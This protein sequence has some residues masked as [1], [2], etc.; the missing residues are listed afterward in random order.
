MLARIELS[1]VTTILD[2]G[3][4]EGRF[5][6][7][8]AARGLQTAGIDPSQSLIRQARLLHPQGDYRAAYAEELPFDDRT[9]DAV[10]AYM[11]LIDIPD[12]KA[13]IREMDRV[14]RPGGQ[15]LIA[16]LNGFCSASNPAGWRV[17][18]DGSQAFLIDHYMTERSDWIGWGNLRVQNWHRPLSTY[19]SLLLEAGFELKFFDE[20]LPSG[21]DPEQIALF[22][23]VPSF[24]L[25]DWKKP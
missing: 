16:N 10:V 24:V 6:R 4:G 21:G 11:S 1:G 18:N 19:M 9:F 22:K 5:S 13:A 7:M 15:L 17:E 12:L 20:P 14:L 25:M 8:L 23:R 2:V 3:C